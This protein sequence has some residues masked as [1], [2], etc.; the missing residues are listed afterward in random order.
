MPSL[1][2][3][4]T[5]RGADAS[6]ILPLQLDSLF[7]ALGHSSRITHFEWEFQLAVSKRQDFQAKQNHR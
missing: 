3:T 6:D 1:H 5:G 4:A 7:R 2:T